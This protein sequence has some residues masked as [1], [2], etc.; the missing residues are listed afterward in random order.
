MAEK[1]WEQR[2]GELLCK[3]AYTR[4]PW[5]NQNTGALLMEASMAERELIL[6]L[7]YEWDERQ[8]A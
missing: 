7:A 8:R 4:S 5:V 2:A 6:Q 3:L 1:I